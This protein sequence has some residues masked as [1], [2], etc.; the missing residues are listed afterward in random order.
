[1]YKRQNLSK[2]IYLIISLIILG[3][4]RVVYG[5]IS[6]A[7]GAQI[8]T[9]EFRKLNFFTVI[10]LLLLLVLLYFTGYTREAIL[11]VVIA[12]WF[13]RGI[14]FY[15]SIINKLQSLKN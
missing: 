11:W 9:K 2:D 12:M 14:L 13:S 8:R 6:A 7:V 5:I 4:T 1:M 15:L 3:S 10:S